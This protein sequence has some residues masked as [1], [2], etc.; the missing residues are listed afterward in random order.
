MDRL[1][2]QSNSGGVTALCQ[3]EVGYFKIFCGVAATKDEKI[4]CNVEVSGY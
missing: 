4:G 2:I 1:T 3:Y